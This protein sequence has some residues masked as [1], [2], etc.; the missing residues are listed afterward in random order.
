LTELLALLALSLVGLLIRG[1]QSL[2]K[3]TGAISIPAVRAGRLALR[4]VVLLLEVAVRVVRVKLAEILFADG[5]L[6][7]VTFAA[8]VLLTPITLVTLFLGI[9]EL[10]VEALNPRVRFGF[11][12]E[13]EEGGS[14]DD[15]QASL[16]E[17]GKDHVCCGWS[18]A[19]RRM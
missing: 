1:L 15:D 18:V 12:C 8:S 19:V 3:S 7:S 16:G 13:D 11:L 5:E 17:S 2:V 10:P 14:E 4:V 9:L 6:A